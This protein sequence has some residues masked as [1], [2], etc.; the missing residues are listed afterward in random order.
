VND[1]YSMNIL[2][3]GLFIQLLCVTETAVIGV[4]EFTLSPMAW[5]MTS[6]ASVG[7]IAL[8]VLLKAKVLT[9]KFYTALA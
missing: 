6:C 1:Y 4:T 2:T 8:N 3:V 9:K 5:V 7:L